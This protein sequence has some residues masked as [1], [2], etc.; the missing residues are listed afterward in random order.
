MAKNNKSYISDI[1]ASDMI[2]FLETQKALRL[3][4]IK[5]IDEQLQKYKPSTKRKE[6]DWPLVVQQ[7]IKAIGP[8]HTKAEITLATQKKLAEWNIT[9]KTIKNKVAT[10]L[11]FNKNVVKD[12]IGT[13]Y[14]YSLKNERN[15]K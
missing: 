8:L 5:Y 3:Q 9:S 1:P 6:P 10:E 2:R 12:R 7:V 4:E 13:T 15:I 11:L 14:K